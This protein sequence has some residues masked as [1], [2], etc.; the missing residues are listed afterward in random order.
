MRSPRMPGEGAPEAGPSAREEE[1]KETKAK[2]VNV[3]IATCMGLW[4]ACR[5][6]TAH[7]H[8]CAGVFLSA[9]TLRGRA[10][11]TTSGPDPWLLSFTPPASPPG[12]EPTLT[13][14]H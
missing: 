6:L 4:W 13:V 10:V 3:Q 1:P 5:G 8:L 11:P 7:S 12:A 9:V 14:S 2:S